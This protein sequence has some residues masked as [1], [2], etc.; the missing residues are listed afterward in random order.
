MKPILATAALLLIATPVATQAA[1]VFC[2]GSTVVVG[3]GGFEPGSFLV[4]VATGASTGNCVQAADKIFGGFSVGGVITGGGSAGWLFTNTTGPAD[5]SLGFQGL[6]GPSSS[7]FIDY[8]VAVDP[9]T[10]N[11]ALITALQ[12]DFTLNGT[13]ADATATLTGTIS[14][15][16]V[17][18]SGGD[19]STGF[20]CTRTETTSTCPQTGFFNPAINLI[21]VNE[22]ITTGPDTNVTG[23]TDTVFQAV[24]EPG[25][26]LGLLS[27]AL[28]GFYFPFRGRAKFFPPERAV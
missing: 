9:A 22:T 25:S 27:I 7:G 17:S 26:T 4:N 11:G 3:S 6:V 10:S 15:A 24:P 8:S 1:P 21:S 19:I 12:K 23:I 14:P 2:T 20:K 5:V 28:V 18:F 16:A 13:A